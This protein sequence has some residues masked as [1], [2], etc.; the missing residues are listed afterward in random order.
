MKN[1]VGV[2]TLICIVLSAGFVYAQLAIDNDHVTITDPFGVQR[3]YS[4]EDINQQ[5]DHANMAVQGDLLKQQ[6]D[7]VALAQ[8]QET[9]YSAE[10]AINQANFAQ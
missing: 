5:I 8:W 3:N 7:D 10:Q 6:K 1:F 2:L 4:L 9:F